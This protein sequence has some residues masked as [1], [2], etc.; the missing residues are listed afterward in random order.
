[1]T[2]KQIVE[3]VEEIANLVIGVVGL[4][5]SL[6]VLAGVFHFVFSRM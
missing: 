3:N 1:M 2:T 4:V 6:S 5:I